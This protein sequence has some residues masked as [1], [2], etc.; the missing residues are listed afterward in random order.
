[1]SLLDPIWAEAILSVEFQA[2]EEVDLQINLEELN[3]HLQKS[4]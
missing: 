1:M 2:R 4:T 3:R